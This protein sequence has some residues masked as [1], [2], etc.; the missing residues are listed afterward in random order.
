MK[1]H[2]IGYLV[3]DINKSISIFQS[4]GY[5]IE[6]DIIYD[7]YREIDICFLINESERIELVAPKKAESAVGELRKK[8]GNA[9]YHICYETDNL[10]REI[11]NL[12]ANRFVIWQEP[13]EAP[14]IDGQRVAFLV[15]GQ[16]GLIEL[17]ETNRG[18]KEY[19]D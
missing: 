9:P 11:Q 1:V 4:L 16:I 15:N 6:K 8:I 13:L 2:H 5:S 10:E 18:K 3:K 19:A 14:A 12:R 17:V 7:Q